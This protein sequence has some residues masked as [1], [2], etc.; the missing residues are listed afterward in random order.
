[1]TGEQTTSRDS[2]PGQPFALMTVRGRIAPPGQQ[3]PLRVPERGGLRQFYLDWEKG[4][5]DIVAAMRSYA[6]QRPHDKPLTDLI[7]ELVTRSDTFRTR[8][9][10]S[11]HSKIIKSRHNPR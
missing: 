7:G 11:G 8:W 6:D 3:R 10:A 4:P 1:M 9:A 2:S 5:D